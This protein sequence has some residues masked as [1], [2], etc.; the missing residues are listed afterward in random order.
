MRAIEFISEGPMDWV[1][2]G[3]KKLDNLKWAYKDAKYQQETIEAVL[4]QWNK[5]SAEVK[6]I[7]P[8]YDKINW[9]NELKK[10]ADSHFNIATKIPIPNINKTTITGASGYNQNL[11]NQYISARAAEFLKYQLPQEPTEPAEPTAARV[12]R[13]RSLDPEVI[14]QDSAGPSRMVSVHPYMGGSF[15]YNVIKNQW[16]NNRN[17]TVIT[18]PYMI[19]QLN[20]SYNK[21]NQRPTLYNQ[22]PADKFAQRRQTRQNAATQQ[23]RSQMGIT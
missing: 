17:N 5:Y 21:A 8:S 1:R 19:K 16:I 14:P 3:F 2:S 11:V 22:T 10:F 7:T 18:D 23:V 15:A 4:N 20:I 13:T 9:N 12:A 6:A